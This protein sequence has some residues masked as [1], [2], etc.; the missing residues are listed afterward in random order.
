MGL[1]FIKKST[2]PGTPGFNQPHD[3]SVSITGGGVYDA[4]QIK[5][6]FTSTYATTALIGQRTNHFLYVQPGLLWYVPRRFT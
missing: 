3:H 2:I 4:G 1:D 6:T 5:W